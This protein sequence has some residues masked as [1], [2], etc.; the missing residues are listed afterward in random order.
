[1]DG[2]RGRCCLKIS[3]NVTKIDC[4]VLSEEAFH[5]LPKEELV[6]LVS[7]DWKIKA[8]FEKFAGLV[9]APFTALTTVTAATTHHVV[10]ALRAAAGRTMLTTSLTILAG[11]LATAT[12]HHGGIVAAAGFTGLALSFTGLAL[13]LTGLALSLRG[14]ALGFTGCATSLAATTH[15]FHC[16]VH[17]LG[18]RF[19]IH[20]IFW[21]KKKHRSSKEKLAT[22]RKATC[23]PTKNANPFL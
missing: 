7:G 8:F 22:Q 1:M 14:L 10:A 23:Q 4:Y 19:G 13:S 21:E 6:I 17:R 11:G 18:H 9:L 16:L 20:L 15:H 3:E 12:T 2:S 5:K